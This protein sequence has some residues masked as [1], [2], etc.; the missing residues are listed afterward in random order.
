MYYTTLLP[1]VDVVNNTTGHNNSQTYSHLD[2]PFHD[3]L[4]IHERITI[5]VH[6][7]YAYY[8]TYTTY[9]VRVMVYIHTVV[10][11]PIG[12]LLSNMLLIM[13]TSTLQPALINTRFA[14]IASRALL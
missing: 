4:L 3:N 1:E 5:V 14:S 12:Y 7:L 2:N 8:Y 6:I 9:H 13:L 11:T 10:H